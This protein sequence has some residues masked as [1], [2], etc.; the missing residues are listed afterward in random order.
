M[1]LWHSIFR[2]NIEYWI[3]CLSYQKFFIFS[4]SFLIFI[5]GKLNYLR[6]SFND[7]RSKFS[8]AYTLF[9][10]RLHFRW[11]FVV[12]ENMSHCSKKCLL[13]NFLDSISLGPTF[14]CESNFSGPRFFSTQIFSGTKVF[15]D[16]K[17]IATQI[18]LWP[19]I[20]F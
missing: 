2:S 16:P 14:F 18:F 17:S 6:L 1:L 12:S 13:Q 19:R 15:Q 3:L 10:N 9:T 20:F 5:L 7:I 11:N 8:K 4:I